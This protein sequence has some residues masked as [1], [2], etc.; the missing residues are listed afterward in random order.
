MDLSPPPLSRSPASSPNTDY[1]SPGLVESHYKLS[2]LYDQSCVLDHNMDSEPLSLD[3]ASSAE[4]SAPLLQATTST[5]IPNILAAPYDAFNGY[6][7]SMPPSYPHDIYVSG[8]TQTHAGSMSPQ[9]F[10]RT[11]SHSPDPSRPAFA[12]R[13]SGSPPPQ[14]KMENGGEYPELDY[15][16]YPSPHLG[17]A[18]PVEIGGYSSAA[19]SSGYLSDAPS[20][21]WPKSEYTTLESDM[22]TANG[23]A[24]A[25]P[26]LL[27]DR[28]PYRIHRAPR[29][30]P[31]RLTTK[32]EANYQ[33]E[34][35]G[36]GKLFSRSYNYK[37]HLETHDENREYPFPCAAIGCSK[38]FVRKTD[39]QRHHQSVH[40]KEKNH[41]CD[42]CSRMFA[43]KDT[44][45]RHMEDGCSKR[46]DIGTLDVR[47]EGYDSSFS[48]H[49]TSNL[50]APP[51]QLPPMT[52]SRP[53]TTNPNLLEPAVSL[54]RRG[55]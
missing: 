37:A 41:R 54:M 1:P 46:F 8:H 19:S 4:W 35:K 18:V 2:S 34:V 39:L 49:S 21:S 17:P 11:L 22:F 29:S 30:R 26:S 38:R 53:R 23:T 52:N 16:R 20:G 5:D 25:A 51:T 7:A 14:V 36:C 13:L 6:D 40:M 55:Y 50:L 9:Q 32:E 15:S 47:S 45:R 28:Q 43:R 31:R 48:S 44:L 24:P 33:C 42:Y 12:Y 10:P 27:Q 3:T